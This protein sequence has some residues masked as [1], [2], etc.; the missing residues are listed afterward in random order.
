MNF[1][2]DIILTNSVKSDA[3]DALDDFNIHHYPMISIIAKNI[4]PFNLSDYDY[5]IFTSQ[6][7]V[8][9]FFDYPFVR[10]QY[11]KKIKAICSGQ[12]TEEKL[13]KLGATISFS[14]NS[15]YAKDMINEL[16]ELKFIEN[17]KILVIV[18]SLSDTTKYE[19]LKKYS[20]ISTLEIYET[21]KHTKFNH[22]LDKLLKKGNSISVF[23]SPSSF[24]VFISIYN[25]FNTEIFSIGETT[26][27]YI[28]SQGF[29]VITS[30]KQ[31]FESLVNEI[32]NNN[33]QL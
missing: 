16:K 25:S 9:I 12:K 28:K 27:E 10:V 1:P 32:L 26:S 31:T 4:K 30:K 20:Q 19:E 21:K 13:R 7:S 3:F 6:N 18:G 15:S 24:E 5:Y 33:Y 29:D 14:S 2:K 22:R 23:A 17:S 8:E 11:E